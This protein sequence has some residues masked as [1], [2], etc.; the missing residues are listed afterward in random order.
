M[1]KLFEAAVYNEDVLLAIKDGEHHKDLDDDWAD[2][3]YF[4]IEARNAEEAWDIARRKWRAG[5]GFVVKAIEQL[6]K[7]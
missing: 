5:H 4:E 2:T 1:N 3:H 6:S 7:D